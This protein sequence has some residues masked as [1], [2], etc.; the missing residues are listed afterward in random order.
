MRKPEFLG[1]YRLEQWDEVFPLT[2]D[3][4]ALGRFATLRRGDRVCDLGCGSGVLLLLAAGREEMLT[5]TGVDR[6]P[7]AVTL[8][9]RNLLDNRLPGRVITADVCC[10]EELPPPESFDVV[11]CNPPYYPAGS[12]GDGGAARME[13]GGTL[14]DFLSAAAYLLRAG[15][16]LAMVHR[17]ERLTDLL[18]GLR[19][20]RLEP[21]RIQAQPP[22]VLVEAVKNARPGGL[23]W[24]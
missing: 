5:L 11:L 4:L 9:G 16:R 1:P 22:M 6:D 8:T 20:H 17:A 18:C 23:N 2:G 3:A 14:E 10:R 21:K 15:G 13:D 7:W 19:K 12:G 24:E